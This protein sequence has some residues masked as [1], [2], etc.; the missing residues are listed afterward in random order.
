M[1]W[2]KGLSL[3]LLLIAAVS[4]T[5][6]AIGPLY[7]R[8][9]EE[10]LLRDRLLSGSIRAEGFA[11]GYVAPQAQDNPALLDAARSAARQ[12]ALD[13][14]FEPAQLSL[15]AATVPV[16][17]TASDGAP[18]YVTRLAWRDGQCAHLRLLAGSCPQQPGEALISAAAARALGLK[19][20]GRLLLRGVSR[21]VPEVNHPRVTGVY[22]PGNPRAA[23][24]FDQNFFDAGP[25]Q[26]DEPDRLDTV[27][28]A[29]SSIDRVD[30]VALRADAQRRLRISAVR[31]DDVTPLRAA[32]DAALARL[33]LDPGGSQATAG[34]GGLL[35]QVQKERRVVA[36]SV[37]LVTAQLV[38]LTWFV[39]FLIVAGATEERSGEVALAKLRGLSPGATT[40]FGLAEPV[41]LL[42]A[43]VP[44]GVAAAWLATRLL[45]DG[46]LLT[47]TPVEIRS[48]VLLAVAI[49]L[50]G[51]AVAAVLAARRILTLP[52]LDQLRRASGEGSS[53]SRSVAVDAVAVTFAAAGIYQLV[54]SGQLDQNKG[55]GI[56]LLTPGLLAVAVALVGVRLLPLIARL[57][58]RRSRR[59]DRIAAFLSTRQISRRPAALRI[60]VLLTVA[61]AL[62]TFAVDGWRVAA[63]NRN[64]RAR[65]EV[66]AYQVLHVLAGTEAQLLAATRAADPSGRYAMAVAELI[67][68]GADPS[69]AHV[70]AVD[71]PRLAAV[72]EW[73]RSWAGISVGDL[74][75]R[76][77]PALPPP[78]R[79]RGT[80]LALTVTTT[81]NATSLPRLSGAPDLFSHPPPAPRLHVSAVLQLPDGR[82][83]TVPLGLA[84]P[85]GRSITLRTG[86]PDCTAGCRLALL[87]FEEDL[88]SFVPYD[89]VLT[90]TSLATSR[91]D[92]D[93]GLAAA[94]RWRSVQTDLA[95]S[96]HH[97]SAVNA[98]AKGLVVTLHGGGGDV[99]QVS[100]ADSPGALPVVFG[101]Q[102]PS[103][104][105]AGTPGY[106]SGTGID[107]QSALVSVVFTAAVLPRTGRAGE[108]ADLEYADRTATG[109]ERQT[110]QQVWLAPGTP[111]R[112]LTALAGHGIEVHGRETV[113]ARRAELDR[114]G[115]ALALL[116][117]VVA[118]VAGLLLAVAA[119][120]TTVYIGGRRRAYE[121]AAMRT[122]GVP[123]RTLVRAGTREQLILLGSGVV[124]G[125]AAGITAALLALP[126]VPV[127][128]DRNVGPPLVFTPVW[129]V[130]GLMLLVAA[131]TVA[132][133]GHLAA[134]QLVR[135]SLPDRL[136]EA[137]A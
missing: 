88:G 56:A 119:V 74:A 132:A 135:V 104:P 49:A 75:R 42:S 12:P 17:R 15:Q 4:M 66:G 72:G 114:Q 40:A 122:F 120:V 124:L 73:D 19:L 54:A 113:G 136:R 92:V 71:S 81:S 31:L 44:V 95:D 16:L 34:I 46:V 116:L 123:R 20:G 69:S 43:S 2:R 127:Y 105:L 21:S 80:S 99:P 39:L 102:T 125:G 98:A 118:A 8:A 76:L 55:N 50:V 36:V 65:E 110:D 9:A 62:A 63:R 133:V 59:T 134:R 103:S 6:A 7:S 13:R 84:A 117:F 68:Q 78:V 3:T 58:V 79:I 47:G 51:G 28:V 108:L 100:P 29:K 1:L 87:Q 106:T 25:G 85:V 18:S 37:P 64:D 67:P 94:G 57:G 61:V 38:L 70:L 26:G 111:R 107:G 91:G 52:V 23:F 101:A 112:V 90:I 27:F 115:P 137:Q 130:L 30:S 86:T 32:I 53:T 14:Y 121:L 97:T 126:A 10:S 48:P 5:A 83:R 24:W 41:L 33:A 35:D 22:Q 77:R 45:A 109:A 131:M 89:A 93:A 11:V 82:Q 129:G 96:T 60:V 128:A